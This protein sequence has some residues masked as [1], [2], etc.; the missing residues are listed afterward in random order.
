MKAVK[1]SNEILAVAIVSVAEPVTINSTVNL[2]DGTSTLVPVP[3]H[4]QPGDIIIL[5]TDGTV[6][7][8]VVTGE[9]FFDAATFASD[10]DV[11][12]G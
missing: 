10:F 11:L 12:A 9:S 6:P 4:A 3:A 8:H 5:N 2:P 7:A 1:K